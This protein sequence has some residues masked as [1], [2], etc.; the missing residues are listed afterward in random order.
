[1][2]RVR[3]LARNVS[4]LNVLLLCCI[5]AAALYT[6]LP[7][8]RTKI[9]VTLKPSQETGAPASAEA[10]QPEQVPSLSDYQVVAEMNLFHPE[11]KVPERQGERAAA[12]P[13]IILYGTVV[14]GD[15]SLAYIEDLKAPYSSPGRGKRQRTLKKGESISG[16]VL[17]E[18]LSNRIVLA[19]GDET[20]TVFLE[21][22]KKVRSEAQTPPRQTPSSP[23]QVGTPGPAA[24]VPLVQPQDMQTGAPIRSR[25][26]PAVLDNRPGREMP[27]PAGR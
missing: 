14:A 20:M 23:A 8:T 22:P 13:E 11:R 10:K 16:F 2:G 3:Y 12:R 24:S 6:I 5:V 21:D 27:G 19:K 26:P 18:V 1:M 15:M 9:S 17:K 7:L 25:V 4:V